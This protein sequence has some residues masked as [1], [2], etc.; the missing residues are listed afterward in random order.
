M[1]NMHLLFL[2][3]VLLGK[4][5]CKFSDVC[6]LSLN[7]KVTENYV[8]HEVSGNCALNQCQ[9]NLLI[10]VPF[11]KNAFKTLKLLQQK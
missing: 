11:K 4:L 5:F 3:T 7:T 8:R 1:T 2:F 10:L 6:T 9:T